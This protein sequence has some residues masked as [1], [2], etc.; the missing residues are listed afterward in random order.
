VA[1]QLGHETLTEP[2]HLVVCPPLRIEIGSAFAAA[3]RQR[4]QR[5]LEYLLEGEKLQHAQRHRG[6]ESEAALVRSNRAV[7]LHAISAIHLHASRIVLPDDPEHHHPFGF[8]ET[9]DNPRLAIFRFPVDNEGEAFEYLFYG[10]VELWLGGVFRSDAVE[11]IADE[12]RSLGAR[13]NMADQHHASFQG[14]RRAPF[15]LLTGRT[16]GRGRVFISE[17]APADRGLR[18]R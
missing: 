12:L 9:L 2:H 7:H 16:T 8:D 11:D 18:A 10:L 17:I 6:V 14:R 3:H 1:L 13:G 15:Q 5:V 4:R